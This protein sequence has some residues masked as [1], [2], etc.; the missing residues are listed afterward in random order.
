MRRFAAGVLTVMAMAVAA[1]AP[2]AVSAAPRAAGPPECNGLTPALATACRV[3]GAAGPALCRYS[4][5]PE[6]SCSSLPLSPK[7]RRAAVAAYRRSWTHRALTL[8]YDLANDVG[9]QNVPWPGTHNSFNSVAEM[10]PTLSD[11]DSNQQLSI[12]DLLDLD[13]REIELDVHLQPSVS[14]GGMVP[15]VCHARDTAHAGCTIEKPMSVV[16][17]E[18]AGWLRRPENRGQA[19]RLRLEDHLDGKTGQAMAASIVSER[20]GSLLY[21]PP[22]AATCVA[23]PLAL[24]RATIL[25]S[26]AQ[27]FLQGDC[28]GAS[29]L[30]TVAF[31]NGPYQ[32]ETPKG[33]ADFPVCGHD[34]KR[35]DYE[36]KIIRYFEDSTGLSAAAGFGAP[37]DGNTPGTTARMARCGVDIIDFDQLLPDDG[38]LDSLVWSWAPGEP[39]R[40]GTCAV[41]VVNAHFPFGR[42]E[43]RPC[44]ERHRVACRTL[45]GT[46]HVARGR[47]LRE[48]GA[49]TRCIR[50]RRGAR[51]AVPRTGYEAQRLRM[52][53]RLAHVDTVW[54]ATR[55]SGE[56][57]VA[58]DR[59]G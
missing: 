49:A 14:G 34:F 58:R 12:V 43:S 56:R 26:G 46:W 38:R 59:R 25:A 55:R 37:D 13:V 27:V 47:A 29:G 36:R 35:T 54:L 2:Q 31:A 30:R 1:V 18:I 44:T 57:W 24:N 50:S 3:L 15:V 6:S 23:P 11:T 45:R 16:L 4:G 53:M 10:G 5:L 51:H 39:A 19:I 22:A 7:V 48:S 40:R 52:A 17:G 9:I 28:D 20:L 42:W 41:Q 8:Q 33:Y 32:E 21:R